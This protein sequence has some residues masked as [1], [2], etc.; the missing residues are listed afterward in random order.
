MT[1]KSLI[2]HNE[3]LKDTKRDFYSFLFLKNTR[4]KANS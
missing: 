1:V 2:Y 4:E 3:K